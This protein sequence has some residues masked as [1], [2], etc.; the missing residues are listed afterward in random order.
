MS[1]SLP[2][3]SIDG[4]LHS[5][6]VVRDLGWAG[7]IVH[8]SLS[9]FRQK[10]SAK[11]RKTKNLQWRFLPETAD[12]PRRFKGRTKR[13]QGKRLSIEG[14]CGTTD[15]WEA[16]T[17]AVAASQER[18]RILHQQ[19]EQQQREQNQ[20]LS[21]YWERLYAHAK[22]QSRSNRNRWLSDKRNLL[23]GLIG[24]GLQS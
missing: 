19:L 11:S 2:Q 21:V 7:A 18:W 4:T 1:R 10:Q 6:N 13:G 16:V 15:P 9:V 3:N 14:T 5:L 20:S 8:P 12:D 17:I 22:Q 23:N 24:I